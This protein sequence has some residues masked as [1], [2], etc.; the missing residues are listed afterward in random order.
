VLIVDDHHFLDVEPT[1]VTS[2]GPGCAAF[3]ADAS[4]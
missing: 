3:L 1:G 4:V 2:S